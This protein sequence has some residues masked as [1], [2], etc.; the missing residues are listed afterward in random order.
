MLSIIEVQNV[1]KDFSVEAAIIYNVST[2]CMLALLWASGDT[3]RIGVPRV[4]PRLIRYEQSAPE[5]SRPPS[6]ADFHAEYFAECITIVV[7]ST[8]SN[9]QWFFYLNKCLQAVLSD[10]T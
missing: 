9:S 3:F 1:F 4:F 8:G 10:L 5:I 7:F 6:H 2:F